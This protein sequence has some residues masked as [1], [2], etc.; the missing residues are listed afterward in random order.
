VQVKTLL[1]GEG[2][3]KMKGGAVEEAR[4]MG[5]LLILGL[6]S[7]ILFPSTVGSG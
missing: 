6:Y 1:V 5:G 7:L 2:G 4:E 3:W